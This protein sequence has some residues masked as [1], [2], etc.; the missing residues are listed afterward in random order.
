VSTLQHPAIILVS[1]KGPLNVG[2]VARLMGNFGLTDLRLVDPRCDLTSVDCKQMAMHSYDVVRQ[3]KIFPDVASAISDLS[4]VIALSGREVED[5]RPHTD[6]YSIQDTV[7]PKLLHSDRVGIVFGREEIGLKLEELCLCH[8]Q[9]IIPTDTVRP[10]INLTS[11][12]AMTL[13]WWNQI[14][15]NLHLHRHTDL[16]IER[17]EHKKVTLFFER[18]QALLDTTKFTN[19]E[20]PMQLR[21]DLWS[22]YH[23]ADLDDRELRILFGILAS[24]ENAVRKKSFHSDAVPQVLES[25]LNP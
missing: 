25:H 7:I 24:V 2:G 23:R 17:P 10:S 1:P 14:R 11:A 4:Q 18:L 15:S 22:I 5:R 13:S 8:W 21:D 12:V 9:I 3:A 19:K 20:N 16:E 6:L